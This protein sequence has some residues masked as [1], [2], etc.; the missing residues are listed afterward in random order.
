M[1]YSMPTGIFAKALTFNLPGKLSQ[2][3]LALPFAFQDWVYAG[4]R[5]RIVWDF[6]RGKVYLHDDA[7]E[8]MRRLFSQALERMGNGCTR[9]SIVWGEKED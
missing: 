3:E 6:G 9:L 7:P 5:E 1:R 8:E 2:P 4:W